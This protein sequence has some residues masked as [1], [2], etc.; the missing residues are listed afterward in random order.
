MDRGQVG[1]LHAN[2]IIRL[3]LTKTY[4]IPEDALLTCNTA[5]ISSRSSVGFH[6]PRSFVICRGCLFFFT[7]FVM[8]AGFITMVSGGVRA[9]PD[10]VIFNNK[11]HKVIK[12]YTVFYSA[13]MARI[14]PP[15]GDLNGLKYLLFFAR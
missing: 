12:K 15:I 2:I 14:H 11:S 8:G 13:K 1:G 7:L 9:A 3:S 6:R 4:K 10:F 5:F